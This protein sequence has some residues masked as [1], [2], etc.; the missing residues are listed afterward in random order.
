MSAIPAT[1]YVVGLKGSLDQPLELLF[2]RSL[3]STA[4]AGVSDVAFG[5]TVPNDKILCLQS[6]SLIG[7]SD[8][9]AGF[10]GG[11][12]GYLFQG[13]QNRVYAVATGAGP[14]TAVANA[15]VTA[16]AQGEVWVPPGAV[17]YLDAQWSA[18][19]G[20]NSYLAFFTG[21]LW[22]RGNIALA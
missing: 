19:G 8:T 1:L 18:G 11:A 13:I 5:Y 4:L 9:G 2:R 20:T 12:L 10:V 15:R 6:F 22:P 14:F 7:A 17:L 21:L 3:G 16:G